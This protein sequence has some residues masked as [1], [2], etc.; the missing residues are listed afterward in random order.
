M[1]TTRTAFEDLPTSVHTAIEE[2]TG[3]LLKIETTAA[4]FNSEI[5]ARVHSTTGTCFIKGLRTDHPRAWTQRREAEVNPYLRGIAPA[6]LWHLE[7]EGWHLL[8]FE[9]LDGHHADYSPGSP[10]LPKVATALR[11]LGEIPCPQIELRHAEQRLRAYVT[12]EGQEQHFAGSAL[13]H[14]DL[15]NANVLVDDERALLVDWAW[16]T[17]GAPWLDAGYWVIWLIVGGH[18]P[19]T[20]EEWAA[21]VPTWNTAPRAGIDVFA[22]ANANLWEEI[23]GPDPDPWTK[24]MLDAARRWSAHRSAR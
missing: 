18:T 5:S 21:R 13:L 1:A 8:A 2:H 22:E 6:L 11:H 24:R 12:D 3:P 4:G 23:A 16:A 9:A 20:A 19:K 7:A 14:T 15:N 17:R 10:D